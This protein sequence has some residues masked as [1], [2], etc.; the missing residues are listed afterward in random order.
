MDINRNQFFLAGLVIFLL[1]VQF[2]SIESIV[3]TPQCT[4][5]LGESTGNK[6]LAT[7]DSASSFLGTQATISSMPVRPPEWIGWSLLSLGSVLI[8]HSLAMKKP[9]A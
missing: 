5:L 3:L 9:G 8:L 7:A 1:G 6:T 2:R 4:R